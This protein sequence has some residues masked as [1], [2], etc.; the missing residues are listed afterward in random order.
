MPLD[1]N[2]EIALVDGMEDFDGRIVGG[3]AIP[4][5]GN[6][7]QATLEHPPTL[8]QVGGEWHQ[9]SV[10]NS[11]GRSCSWT[12]SSPISFK[13][14]HSCTG[15]SCRGNHSSSEFRG[16]DRR[17]ALLKGGFQTGSDHGPSFGFET[18]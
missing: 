5:R 8:S 2:D 12:Y 4:P 6:T 17:A 18:P 9:W 7:T 11:S 15:E 16:F 10:A 1:R 3:N 13:S 14:G